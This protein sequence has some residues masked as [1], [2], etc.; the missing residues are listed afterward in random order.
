MLRTR[1]LCGGP[2]PPLYVV[3]HSVDF[4]FCRMVV[5]CPASPLVVARCVCGSH[6]SNCH[7]IAEN[8]RSPDQHITTAPHYIFKHEQFS[9]DVLRPVPVE[10][11]LLLIY[12][13]TCLIF[14]S[15]IKRILAVRATG[16]SITRCLPVLSARDVTG[17]VTIS[18]IRGSAYSAA[19]AIAIGRVEPEMSVKGWARG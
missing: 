6:R 8:M 18:H 4:E 14:L 10:F 19:C 11:P 12:T 15:S 7:T 5:C 2:S 3:H 17:L 1:E 16:R 9:L 13:R